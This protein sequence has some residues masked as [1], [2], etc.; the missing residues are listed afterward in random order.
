MG[1][2]KETND[3]YGKIA[4]I[5][6]GEAKLKKS[7]I[8]DFNKVKAELRQSRQELR[9]LAQETKTLTQ[10]V[11]DLMDHEEELDIAEV[12]L[13]VNTL[14]ELLER[15]RVLLNSAKTKYN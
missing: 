9:A 4:A 3:I 14:K 8:H 2:Q 15:T 12:E 10:D 6:E 1:A 13:S 5:T 11:I 7:I